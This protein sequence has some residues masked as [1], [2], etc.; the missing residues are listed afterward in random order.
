MNITLQ[1]AHYS[2]QKLFRL[3]YQQ[4]PKTGN[5]L[6]I[7]KNRDNSDMQ[8]S[9]FDKIKIQVSDTS[10]DMIYCPQGLFE[11]TGYTEAGLNNQGMNP[12]KTT[13]I[14]MPF[15]LSDTEVTQKLYQAVT[16]INPSE[17]KYKNP[18]RPVNYV[19]WFDAVIFC[20]KLS[21]IKGLYPYYQISNIKFE[22]DADGKKTKNIES[23]NVRRNLNANGFRLPT[24]YEWEYAAKAGTN[25]KYAG[26][27][28]NADLENY[29]YMGNLGS[30]ASQQPAASVK[31]KKPNEWGFYDMSGNVSEWVDDLF[32]IK[33]N[34]RDWISRSIRGGAYVYLSDDDF[35]VD[36]LSSYVTSAKK[37]FIG[38]RIAASNGYER[39]KTTLE[40]CGKLIKENKGLKKK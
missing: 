27:D 20:I 6:R 17:Q 24:D 11:R 15:F 21:T 30:L 13:Q 16:G 36:Y 26:T 31:S 39:G 10:F 2:K 38:F 9:A 23:A 34:K 14:E 25:N 4:P 32:C 1:C 18:Q 7:D 28:S 8:A 12:P 29:A 3:G 5:N 19:S 35:R 40:I 33:N 22:L 37:N